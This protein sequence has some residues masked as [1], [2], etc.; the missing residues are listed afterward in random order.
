MSN[1]LERKEK[2]R[3]TKYAAVGCSSVE[4][5]KDV[6]SVREDTLPLPQFAGEELQGGNTY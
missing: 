2:A 6:N 4:T 1:T 3:R 5:C